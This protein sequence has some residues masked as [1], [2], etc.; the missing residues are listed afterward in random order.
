MNSETASD[1]SKSIAAWG[2]LK[3]EA[4]VLRCNK[5]AKDA[6]GN[7]FQFQ[8]RL[9]NC[10]STSITMMTAIRTLE[11]LWPLMLTWQTQVVMG[12]RQQKCDL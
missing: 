5:Y 1:T 2:E 7:K 6:K 12:K 3:K 11:M 10:L 9:F 4:L 8:K